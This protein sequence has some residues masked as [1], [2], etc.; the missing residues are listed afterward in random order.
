MHCTVHTWRS[1][2]CC[3]PIK[4][5][6]NESI[7]LQFPFVLTLLCSWW[8]NCYR[9]TSDMFS[10]F[11]Y[12]LCAAYVTHGQ[13][14]RHR[15]GNPKKKKE[16]RKSGR[17]VAKQKD[18]GRQDAGSRRGLLRCAI[19]SEDAKRRRSIAPTSSWLSSSTSSSWRGKRRWRWRWC[20]WRHH[21]TSRADQFFF[22]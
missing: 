20:C 17:P 15:V 12:F 1:N 16:G 4:W 22:S 8:T 19:T 5:T 13:R 11:Y 18:V 2:G 9:W 21:R 3:C 7:R 6:N 10:F 14:R